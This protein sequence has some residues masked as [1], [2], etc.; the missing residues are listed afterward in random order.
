MNTSAEM[1][2]ATIDVMHNHEIELERMGMVSFTGHAMVDSFLNGINHKQ[3]LIKE[4][5]LDLV[6][7]YYGDCNCDQFVKCK[8]CNFKDALWEL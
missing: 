5:V 4:N 3:N 7:F 6:E 8:F 1:E 2:I